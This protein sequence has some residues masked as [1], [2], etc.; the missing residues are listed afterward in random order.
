[1]RVAWIIG[2]GLTV[3][4]RA[5]A[6][7]GEDE[8]LFAG[9]LAQSVAAVIVF[10]ILL[11]VLRRFA[12]GPILQ[13]LQDRENKIKSDLRHAEAAAQEAHAIL[14][15]YQDQLA[16]AQVEVGRIIDQGRA[17]AQ[18]VA[19]TL[20]QQTES[21]LASLRQR[22]QADIGSAKEQALVELYAQAAGLA[23]QVASCILHREINAQDHMRLI[24]ESIQAYSQQQGS[25][26]GD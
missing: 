4:S 15:R 8:S 2:L 20:K 14:Q 26:Q 3:T 7:S 9:T 25:S 23:T 13:G 17:E 21:E 16:Q 6:A 11:A 18:R 19:A 1:M 10:L 5:V 12:W 22:A 24:D